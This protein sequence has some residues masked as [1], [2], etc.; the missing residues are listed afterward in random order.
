MKLRT[1]R[2]TPIIIKTSQQSYRV[3][4]VGREVDLFLDL[5]SKKE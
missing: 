5:F 4:H 1:I 3:F 2:I